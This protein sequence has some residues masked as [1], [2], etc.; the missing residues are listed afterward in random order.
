[1]HI[2]SACAPSTCLARPRPAHPRTG[3]PPPTC[4][5]RARAGSRARD[6]R[7]PDAR[8]ARVLAPAPRRHREG[9]RHR[10]RALTGSRSTTTGDAVRA[11][12]SPRRVGERRVEP[13][14][15][16]RECSAALA[17]T[18][19]S[20]SP[21]ARARAAGRATYAGSSPSTSARPAPRL[22]CVTHSATRAPP[23]PLGEPRGRR[24][25]GR[26]L[27]GRRARARVRRRRGARRRDGRGVGRASRRES[28][29]WCTSTPTPRRRA[30]AARARKAARPPEVVDEQREAHA[31]RGGAVSQPA[32]AHRAAPFAGADRP[33][34]ASASAGGAY[35]A[36]GHG[37]ARRGASRAAACARGRP[38]APRGAAIRALPRRATLPRP[39]RPLSPITSVRPVEALWPTTHSAE[40]EGME[41][42]QH[43]RRGGRHS[44][45]ILI[46]NRIRL[47][48]SRLCAPAR[49]GPRLRAR[50]RG[51]RKMKER[52]DNVLCLMQV[53]GK[54]GAKLREGIDL[55]LPRCVP[56]TTARSCGDGRT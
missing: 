43:H 52:D 4:R 18:A 48:L 25:R 9:R 42:A 35:G 49:A 5:A 41:Q 53:T 29:S 55:H 27:D 6:A 13:R 20:T 3:P 19:N 34:A 50:D 12:A 51:P 7:A 15:A 24:R 32:A 40:R 47:K 26:P 30:R 56:A 1:M 17:F 28:T 44:R 23:L 45:A 11:A 8:A 37:A 2:F 21:R 54:H 39:T 31:E 22:C 38:R 33:G 14:P 46:R 36:H 16:S 10:E